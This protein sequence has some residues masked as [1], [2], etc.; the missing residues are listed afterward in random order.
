M[1]N[2][3]I[4]LPE[5]PQPMFRQ[6]CI[7]PDPAPNAAGS[8][9]A[10]PYSEVVRM[11]CFSSC[12]FEWNTAGAGQSVCRVCVCVDVVQLG[13]GTVYR[14][15]T[16]NYNT[17]DVVL[18]TTFC[19]W[20]GMH[21]INYTG[22]GKTTHPIEVY[23]R[24]AQWKK[25]YCVW[26]IWCENWQPAARDVY[27]TNVQVYMHAILHEYISFYT[28]KHLYIHNWKYHASSVMR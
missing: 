12:C 21:R 28:R 27:N 6:R 7:S 8:A 25:L 13:S 11:W 9:W 26:K 2:L 18:L 23:Y 24:Y 4:K 22:K 1:V 20:Y 19:S 16:G 14:L 5:Y 15:I 3:Y 17:D 10:P